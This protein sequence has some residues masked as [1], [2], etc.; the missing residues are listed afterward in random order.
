[1]EQHSRSGKIFKQ[2][3]S[4]PNAIK[5]NADASTELSHDPSKYD[6]QYNS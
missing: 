5:R 6:V 2:N 3:Q 1:M 4:G